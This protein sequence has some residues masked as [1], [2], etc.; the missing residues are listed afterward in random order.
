MG[1]LTFFFLLVLLLLIYNYVKDFFHPAVVTLLLWCILVLIYNVTDHEL[2]DLSNRFYWALLLWIIPFSLSSIL[3][4][5]FDFAFA[6]CL[7]KKHNY[8]VNLLYPI[9]VVSLIV[10]IYGLY[11]KGLY[12]NGDNFFNG[13]RAAGVALL[14]GEEET[15]ELPFYIRI[16]STIASY[17]LIVFLAL[18]DDKKKKKYYILFALLLVLFFVFRSNKSVIAQLIFSLLVVHCLGRK[19]SFK[20]ILIYLA[21]FVLLMFAAHLLR[22]KDSS[23]F[24]IV[25]FISVY[26]LSPLPG[27]DNI[28]NN[29]Y[30]YISSFNGE[31]TFRFF[32]PCLQLLGFDVEVNADSFN[33]HNWT[34]TPLPV[35][36]YTIMFNFYVDYG[37]VGIFCFSTFL[38]A[39]FGILYKYAKRNYQMFRVLYANFFYVLVFQFFSDNFFTF[40]GSVL[41]TIFFT[42]FIYLHISLRKTIIKKTINE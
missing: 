27:F 13:I 22:S 39:F 37:F 31:Y 41:A 3:I 30:N 40:M 42:L 20:N 38:G 7:S 19:I 26:L 34:Y 36:V 15:F 8:C 33:L 11:T 18:Y 29:H 24:D 35:N 32:I 28:L 23:E 14:N 25:K 9:M 5:K 4:C 12:Y 21:G 17:S 1:I 2:Y 10:A 6:H 16:P